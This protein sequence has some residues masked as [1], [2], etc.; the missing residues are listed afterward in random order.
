[1]K[2]GLIMEGGA[3]RGLF[4]AGIIDVMMENQ[5]TFDGAIG[6]SAGAAFGCNF[7]SGQIGRAL[8]YNVKYCKDKRY[9]SMLSLIFTGNLFGKNFCYHKIPEKLDV[10]DIEAFNDNPM[11]FYVVC[12]DI[13]SG[14]PVY[15]KFS[16]AEDNFLDWVRASASLPLVSEIVEVDGLHL[17]DGG[18][19][20]SIPIKYFESIGYD[21]NIVILTRD[22]GYVKKKT[23]A[24]FLMKLSLKKYPNMV[25]AIEN[26]HKMYNDTIEY[27]K[28][29]EEQGKVLV[30][31][32]ENT[33]SI[34]RTTHN[35]EK[36]REV[37]DEG[38]RVAIK[39]LD[40]IKEFLLKE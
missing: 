4:T 20:D 5:I 30:L 17:Q 18:I 2:T 34:E 23:E 21:R 33:L 6:V 39:N 16:K 11:L 35:P 19:S 26:R 12:T 25:K 14:K 9:C 40:V 7:K 15:K 24:N 3:M 32:P 31:R 1:M 28:K 8:R 29:Q 22:K 27:I 36:I 37:Y 10:F 13:E 38:R